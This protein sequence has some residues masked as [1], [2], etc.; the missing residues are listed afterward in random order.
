MNFFIQ[1][2]K[3]EELG[4][5]FGQTVFPS[6]LMDTCLGLWAT[7]KTCWVQGR[8]GFFSWNLVTDSVSE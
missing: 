5:W 3:E 7:S 4:F 6:F 1:F 8:L 2:G